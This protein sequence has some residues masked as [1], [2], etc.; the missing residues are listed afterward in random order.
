MGFILSIHI[1]QMINYSS[2]SSEFDQVNEITL[3][4]N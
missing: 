3:S 2:I 4:R 1:Y